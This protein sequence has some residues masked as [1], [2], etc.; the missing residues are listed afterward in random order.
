M[1]KKNEVITILENGGYIVLNEIYR[2]AHVM[3]AAGE[4]LD[5][6]RYDTAE[7]I[8]TLEGFE[9]ARIGSAWNYTRH[10]RKI[11]VREELK[12]AAAAELAEIRTP[13]NIEIVAKNDVYIGKQIRKGTHFIITVYGDGTHSQ[14]G[15]GYGDLY[16]FRE[17]DHAI[18]FE[19]ESR[20]ETAAQE[21]PELN[22][23]EQTMNKTNL[24][25][26]EI[27]AAREALVNAHSANSENGPAATV[28][29]LVDAIGYDRAREIVA[30]MTAARGDW[31]GR[32]SRDE[33]PVSAKH[34]ICHYIETGRFTNEIYAGITEAN[35]TE[36]VVLRE[37]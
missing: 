15:N 21:E 37:F 29:A 36:F 33:M 11:G 4:N 26:R 24:T 18:C 16:D 22:E 1:M 25:N 9:N 10:V 2:H 27:R 8:G 19:I 5:S 34:M 6:C 35:G 13:G 23:E 28:A 3:S 20:P 32:I 31:D 12:A 7:R 14:P 17:A 30:L